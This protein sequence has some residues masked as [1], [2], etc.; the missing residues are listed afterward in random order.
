[1]NRRALLS[2]IGTGVTSLTAGCASRLSLDDPCPDLQIETALRYDERD[3][4]YIT[5]LNPDVVLV[6]S[7]D[8]ITKLYLRQF[9]RADQRWVE[10]IDFEQAALVGFRFPFDEPPEA[11]EPT[12]LVA[13]QEPDGTI[14]IYICISDTTY[15]G[16][17]AYIYQ[18]L[19]RIYHDEGPPPSAATVSIWVE[20]E[21]TVYS[22]RDTDE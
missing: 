8:D 16:D 14:H 22:T 17:G 10:E 13:E 18:N 7:R 9:S 5:V 1:M 19:L 4:P 3:A 2:T 15:R 12:F 21:K 6:H 20:G 11:E